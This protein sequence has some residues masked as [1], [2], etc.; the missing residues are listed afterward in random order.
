MKRNG[1]SN[2]LIVG[3]LTL[4][5]ALV[6]IVFTMPVSTADASLLK[7]DDFDSF[8]S[9][10]MHMISTYDNHEGEVSISSVGESEDLTRII[11]DSSSKIV[12]KNAIYSCSFN[13]TYFLQYNTAEEAARA[14]EKYA[15]SNFNVTYDYDIT[16]DALTPE[17]VTEDGRW[18]TSVYATSKYNSW[19][20]NE[21][22]NFMGAEPYLTNLSASVGESNFNKVV[23]AVLDSGI[24]TSHQLFTGRLLLDY[25]MNFTT[26]A[27]NGNYGSV[28]DKNGHGTHVSGTIAEITPDSVSILPLKVLN[29]DGNGKVSYIVAALRYITEELTLPEGQS[30][31]VA[32]MSLGVNSAIPSTSLVTYINKAFNKGITCVVSAGNDQ[33]DTANVEPANVAHVITVSALARY[34]TGTKMYFDASYSNFGAAVKFS[35]PGTS[36][37]SAYIKTSSQPAATAKATLSGTSMAAPHVSAVVALVLTNPDYQDLQKDDLFEFLKANV[38]YSKFMRPHPSGSQFDLDTSL[39]AGE[40]WNKYYGYGILNIENLGMTIEGEV[41]FSVENEHQTSDFY[42]TLSYAV[43]SSA[44][45]YYTTDENVSA[46]QLTK[47]S[48]GMIKYTGAIHITES[49]KVTAIA[50]VEDVAKRSATSSKTYY[51][52]NYDIKSNFVISTSGT[53]TNYYGSLATLN[54]QETLKLG[55][56]NVTVRAVGSNVFTSK[57]ETIT[58][59]STLTL[60]GE[61]A[62]YSNTSLRVVN[63]PNASIELGRCAFFKCTRLESINTENVTKVGDSAFA[64]TLVEDYDLSK[65]TSVGNNAFSASQV[66]NVLFGRSLTSI[67]TQTQ[68]YNLEKVYGYAGSAAENFAS[69]YNARFYDLTLKITQDFATKKVVKF[70]NSLVLTL[71]FNGYE[72]S[73]EDITFDGDDVVSSSNLVQDDETSYSLILQTRTNLSVRDHAF[74]VSI[75]DGSNTIS[76][77]SGF[78]IKVVNTTEYQITAAGE[79]YQIL[80]DG[81]VVSSGYKVYRDVTYTIAVVSEEGYEVRDITIGSTSTS[82]GVGV[83]ITISNNNVVVSATSEELHE[84]IVRFTSEHGSIYV[85]GSVVTSKSVDRNENL[86]FTIESDIGYTI[87]RVVVGEAFLTAVDGVYTIENITSDCEVEVVYE[88]AVYTIEV[89]YVNACGTLISGPLNEVDHGETK[90]ITIVAKDGYVVDSVLVNGKSVSVSRNGTFAIVNVDE[91]KDVVVSF[92]KTRAAIFGGES[93]IVMEYFVVFGGMFAVFVLARIVLFLVR[94]SKK[95]KKHY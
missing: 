8:Y 63:L 31:R 64:Y 57:V 65:V 72:I 48:A 40:A 33:K 54:V 47:D 16:T 44:D 35:A 68:I 84:F 27:V 66:N 61:N 4:V 59:P 81:E 24:N 76:S 50:Y 39:P 2:K 95:E 80:V 71:K 88:K 83:D 25:A 92:R 30:L 91:N 82:E 9:S 55:S 5:F 14:Y 73:G 23:V 93:G 74:S 38:D 79:N 41:S 42:L 45:I 43:D 67:G 52:N 34:I 6:A 78:K 94:K 26:E 51:I 46:S 13:G 28:E 85:L 18:S 53:I 12:D 60:I 69:K 86:S 29:G 21:T 70:G 89:T 11:V 75:N 15:N 17:E 36:I 77:R 87:K 62:F 19:G 3:V 37:Y 32:N 90:E 56:S 20:W 58:L 22:T 10:Y 1:I 49:T 7:K